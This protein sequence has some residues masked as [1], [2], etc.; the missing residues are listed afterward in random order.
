M[1]LREALGVGILVMEPHHAYGSGVGGI[2]L[3]HILTYSAK[4]HA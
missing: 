4:L 3:W 2:W 1:V